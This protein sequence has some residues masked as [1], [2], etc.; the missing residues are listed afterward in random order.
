M[1]VAGAISSHPGNFV[2]VVGD[3]EAKRGLLGVADDVDD[4]LYELTDAFAQQAADNL[5]THA[6]G[7]ID[8]LVDVHV[9]RET[10]P[11]HF[12]ASGGVESSK[13]P[14]DQYVSR[15]GSR[16]ADYPVYVDQGTGIHGPGASPIYAVPGHLMGPIRFGDR[17][18]YIRSFKGQEAQHY[19]DA[20]CLDVL[21][22]APARIEL[23]L[24]ELERKINT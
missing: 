18:I 19:S 2:I 21:G 7:A 14:A 13:W 23:A 4:W 20:A 17:S 6:P 16:R 10:A 22:W 12:E 24:P 3:D 9:A 11:G 1:V 8:L 5:R 15:R